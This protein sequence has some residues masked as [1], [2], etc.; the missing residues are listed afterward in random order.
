VERFVPPEEFAEIAEE[1]RRLG[2][3]HVEANPLVRSSYHAHKQV[4]LELREA[5]A[6][7]PALRAASESG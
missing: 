4:G 3:R 6:E 2:F 1:G 5:G 7:P